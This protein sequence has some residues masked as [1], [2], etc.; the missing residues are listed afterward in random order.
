MISEAALFE[1]VKHRRALGDQAPVTTEDLWTRAAEDMSEK[2][3]K[4]LGMDLMDGARARH[5]ATVD[6]FMAAAHRIHVQ[7]DEG[8][9]HGLEMR[10]RLREDGVRK[11]LATQLGALDEALA[12]NGKAV[13]RLGH[14]VETFLRSLRAQTAEIARRGVE[15]AQARQVREEAAR[16]TFSPSPF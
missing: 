9:Q 15:Q 12:R 1:A 16:P 2:R 5:E 14:E 4:P 6:G 13:T 11:T 10:T 8:R 7:K 3:Y